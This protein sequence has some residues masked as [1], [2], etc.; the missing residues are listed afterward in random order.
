MIP[1]SMTL[2]VLHAFAEGK[3]YN[4]PCVD[5]GLNTGNFCDGFHDSY[6]CWACDR[7][8]K[9]FSVK[10]KQPTPLCPYCETLHGCCRFCRGVH[11]CTPPE[12][13]YHWSGT[14]LSLSRHFDEEKAQSARKAQWK[15]RAVD[16]VRHLKEKSP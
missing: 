15:E 6:E 12:T 2:Q 13:Q 5:C 10:N 16:C 14:P 1:F 7:V 3:R 8:P 4:F 11:G 9:D